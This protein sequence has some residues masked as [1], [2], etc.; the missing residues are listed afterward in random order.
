M[1]HAF[2]QAI[3]GPCIQPLNKLSSN[4]IALI[5]FFAFSKKNV[6][7]WFDSESIEFGVKSGS[8]IM[9]SFRRKILCAQL[10]MRAEEYGERKQ[11]MERM[12][13]GEYMDKFVK[14]LF[15]KRIRL[16]KRKKTTR[17]QD[18]PEN[19]QDKTRKCNST[20]PVEGA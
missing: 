16:A 10:G 15:A 9:A 17:R 7:F 20:K 1:Y 6:L 5:F 19:A 18:R 3:I 14:N 11:R 8:Y 4:Q 2:K 12:F 13:T